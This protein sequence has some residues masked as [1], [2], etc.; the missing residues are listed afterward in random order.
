MV[1]RLN[2]KFQAYKGKKVLVMSP[3]SDTSCPRLLVFGSGTIVKDDF[4]GN[5]ALKKP[6]LERISAL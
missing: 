2:V 5:V 3:P 6:L 4:N 1:F